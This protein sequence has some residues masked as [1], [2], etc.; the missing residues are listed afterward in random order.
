MKNK[1]IGSDFDDFLREEG[2]LEEVEAAAIKKV[3]AYELYLEMKRCNISITEM[4]NRLGTSRTAVRRLLDPSNVSLTLLTLNRL[5][6]ALGKK[7]EIKF[8]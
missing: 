6:H 2:I 5:A 8:S 4:A 1:H 3:I 7:L